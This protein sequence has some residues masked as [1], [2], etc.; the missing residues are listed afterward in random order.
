[1]KDETTVRKFVLGVALSAIF[2]LPVSGAETSESKLVQLKLP[3]TRLAC[4]WVAADRRLQP[5]LSFSKVTQAAATKAR[6]VH[7]NRRSG[8]VVGIAY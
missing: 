2:G 4:D 5:L 6:S 7:N 8:I 3:V 1:M